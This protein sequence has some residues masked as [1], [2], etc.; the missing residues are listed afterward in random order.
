MQLRQKKDTKIQ[1]ELRENGPKKA[2]KSHRNWNTLINPKD[3]RSTL[4][5][6]RTPK[7]I[8]TPRTIQRNREKSAQHNVYIIWNKLENLFVQ[9]EVEL[10]HSSLWHGICMKL[11]WLLNTILFIA[12]SVNSEPPLN[13]QNVH[14]NVV[15]KK[16]SCYNFFLFFRFSILSTAF[17]AGKNVELGLEERERSS[18]R[19]RTSE[20]TT[21]KQKKNERAK[22][23]K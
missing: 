6:M 3:H 11:L 5:K 1:N 10:S 7:R 9:C 8:K 18:A 20:R 22:R 15:K 13:V 14:I 12:S 19:E 21:E 2:H 23:I 16:H 17:G 4:H